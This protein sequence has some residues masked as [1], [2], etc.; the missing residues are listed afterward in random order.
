[1]NTEHDTDE[2][3]IWSKNTTLPYSLNLCKGTE[4]WRVQFTEKKW[5]FEP[6]KSTYR[7][8]GRKKNNDAEDTKWNGA[9]VRVQKE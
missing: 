9:V 6:N 2:S 7:S 3:D 5:V 4:I 1:M 8:S